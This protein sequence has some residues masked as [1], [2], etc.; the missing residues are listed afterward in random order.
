MKQSCWNCKYCINDYFNNGII[1]C[2]RQDD[3]TEEEFENYYV[4]N[5]GENCCIYD[6]D[7][8]E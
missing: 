6:E 7:V 3:M 1:D 4:D 8:R 5:E 2:D